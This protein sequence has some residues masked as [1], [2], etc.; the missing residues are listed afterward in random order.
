[1]TITAIATRLFDWLGLRPGERRETAFGFTILLFVI[2]ARHAR[3]R[4]RHALPVRAAG[5][6]PAVG[7]PTIAALALV[8]SRTFSAACRDGP[9]A[10]ADGGAVGGAV[11]NVGFWHLCADRHASTL[12]ALYVWTGL[13]ATLVTLQFWL[14]AGDVLDVGRA[15]RVFA[16]IGA[17]GPA[18]ATLGAAVAGLVVTVAPPRTL[19]LGSAAL[20]TVAALVT[21]WWERGHASTRPTPAAPAAAAAPAVPESLRRD[22]YLGRILVVTVVA[23]VVVTGVDYLFKASVAA[24]VPKAELATSSRATRPS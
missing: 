12:F 16:I 11:A 17:G 4:A 21:R 9:R 23:T 19:I 15:K 8:L 24:H 13:I 1:V 7:L 22:P 14:R 3:D 10:H 18:G 5:D 6:A 20:F 2:W